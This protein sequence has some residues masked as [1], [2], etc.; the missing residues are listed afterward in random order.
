MFI[1]NHRR[2]GA[3]SETF[4]MEVTYG[5]TFEK[6]EGLRSKMLD[7]VVS[8]RRDF[9]PVF[10]IR[11]TDLPAQSKM[12]LSVDI[13]YKSN[14]HL[15]S[16]KA[17]R[18]NAWVCALKNNMA[19]LGIYGPTGNPD[20]PT[21]PQQVTLVPWET[22]DPANQPKPEETAA[23]PHRTDYNLRDKNAALRDEADGVYGDEDDL[24]MTN[25]ARTLP[26]DTALPV[27]TAGGSRALP[28]RTNTAAVVEE[29]E[30]KP[31][32][33]GGPL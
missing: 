23:V 7:F 31:G 9:N 19:D 17:K 24:D 8:Q 30:M 13:K 10:D 22:A 32:A 15:G 5:T 16:L 3:E 2:S 25:P 1:R 18:R 33:A 11:V 26:R 28:R 27:P 20:K 29:F 21:K 14:N 12:I 4:D 6:I